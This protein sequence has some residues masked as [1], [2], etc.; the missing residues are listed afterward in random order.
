MFSHFAEAATLFNNG[1]IFLA[2][3]AGT[4]LGLIFGSLP[5]LTA[6]MGIALLLPL[7]FGMEPVT[8]M[9][10]LL[11][12]Y[13]GAISGGS[14]PAALLNIPGTPSSVATTL[15]AFPMARNG[16]P[17]RALG[18]CIV[19]SMIG[20]M[21]SVLIFAFMSP[22]IA[23]AALRFSAI[24]YATLGLFGLTIIASVSDKSLIK[25]IVA[26]LIGVLISLIGID[27]LTGVVRLTAGIPA[28]IGG[29][30]FMAALIGLFAL[31]QI[32]TDTTT[33]RSDQ[34]SEGRVRV[35]NAYPRFRETFRRWK[36]WSSSSLIGSLVGAIPGAGG[37]IASFLAYDQAKRISRTPEKFGKGHDEGII[38]CESANN[39]MTGG[40]L[41]PMMTLG[42]PGDASAAI[43]MGGLLIHGLQPGPMLFDEQ[44]NIA[45]GIIIAFLVANVFMFSFQS[46]GIKLFVRVL[47]IPRTYLLPFIMVMCILGA[48]GITGSLTSAWILLFFGIF[49]YFLNRHGFSAA[50]VVLG[51]ILG[52]MVE[53]NFR[54]GM[55]MHDGDWSVFFT[56]P[57]SLAFVLLSILA[58]ALPLY[59]HHRG[60]R[61]RK[62]ANP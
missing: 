7:T 9:G 54:R 13:C 41:I 40:A 26:G 4:V 46:V 19:A 44:A 28:L 20:G 39:G 33:S 1:Y 21:V 2:I 42:I 57:I 38:S 35:N 23:E 60:R 58:I 10:M 32:I 59:R 29:V 55:T 18:L 62:Y 25:G 45:Y 17:G 49:G 37:S 31:S 5:G 56:R 3:A 12:V 61:T 14:I 51:M 30:D 47:Q 8:G 34:A 27:S 22:L 48:Y 52:Y 24:E 15:D 50:P 6:T 43:L 53:S 11:G 36:I 16:E